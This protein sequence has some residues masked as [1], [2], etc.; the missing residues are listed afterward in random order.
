MIDPELERQYNNRA[1]VPEHPELIAEWAEKSVA[2]EAEAVHKALDLAYGDSD[3]EMLDLFLADAEG[4]PVHMYI[5]GG[6]WQA[7]TRK[8]SSFVARPLVAAGAHVAVVEYGLC[9][10]VTID[11]IGRQIRAA[12]AWLWR[13]AE[14]FGGNPDNLTVSGHSCGGQLVGMA[15]A[16]DWDG[17]AEGLPAD[18][19][20]GGVSIS[21]L[22][23]LIPLVDT[24]I[25][26][27]VGMDTET[28]RR[29]S[30]LFLDPAA[31]A[32]LALFWGGDETDAFR[33]QSKAMAEI[34]GA[35]GVPALAEAIPG[36]N[37][38]TVLTGM[39][40]QSHPATRAILRQMGLGQ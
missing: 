34:W 30:P 3:S 12:L 14:R 4:A 24:T 33:R 22:F 21:G 7:N 1:N 11:E 6:Y 17:F 19:V 16:T 35:R 5:H 38:F 8:S 36:T 29:N 39:D 27:K 20:K 32:P 26:E 23:D 37:H 25:N 31:A 9:P 18:L 28:A 15:M 40:E 2:W 13:E 10:A